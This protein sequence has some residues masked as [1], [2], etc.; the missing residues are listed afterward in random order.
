MT[1]TCRFCNRTKDISQFNKSKSHSDGH[2][3]K[4]KACKK[5]YKATW[6]RTKIGVIKTI[7]SSQLESSKKRNH[8]E[9]SYTQQEFIEWVQGQRLFDYYYNNW[10]ASGYKKIYKP[11]VDRLDDFKPYSFDNIQ[12]TIVLG[13]QEHAMQDKR[14]GIGTQGRHTYKVRA[15]NLETGEVEVFPSSSYA[16]EVLAL[17]GIV[18]NR[19]N[20]QKVCNGQRNKCGGLSWEYVLE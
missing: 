9:P 7:Y 12:L 4:C 20:I 3:W 14:T 1:K 16:V 2:E 10:V 6:S 15:T 13:N 8:P 18:V 5:I 11:S 17:R 19:Q